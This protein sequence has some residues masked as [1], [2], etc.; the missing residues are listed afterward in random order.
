MA[1]LPEMLGGG[2]SMAASGQQCRSGDVIMTRRADRRN[3]A[4]DRDS[5]YINYPASAQAFSG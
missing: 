1:F 2:S 5:S 3:G 4:C